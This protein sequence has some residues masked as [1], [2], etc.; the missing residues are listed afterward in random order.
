MTKSAIIMN[1]NLEANRTNLNEGIVRY[2]IDNC[3]KWIDTNLLNKLQA[4]N[5]ETDVFLFINTTDVNNSDYEYFNMLYKGSHIAVESTASIEHEILKEISNSLTRTKNADGLLFNNARQFFTF[6][7]K[8]K[9]VLDNFGHYDYIFRV[10]PDCFITPEFKL[11][12]LKLLDNTNRV[13]S[14]NKFERNSRICLI[15]Y[16]FVMSTMSIGIVNDNINSWI[17]DL[18][19]DILH[20]E[21]LYP[22]MI[23]WDLMGVSGMVAENMLH[24]LLEISGT[25]MFIVGDD[26]RSFAYKPIMYSMNAPLLHDIHPSNMGGFKLLQNYHNFF[27]STFNTFATTEYDKHIR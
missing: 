26:I 14:L 2:G 12:N 11:D 1:F 27:I 23:F 10:R 25:N 17:N 5:I 3:K 24:R 7:R 16:M 4:N 18:Y 15:D 6:F 19:K 20:Q 8:S 13:L 22:G 21:T 9:Y